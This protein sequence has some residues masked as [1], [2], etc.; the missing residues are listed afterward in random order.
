MMASWEY[1]FIIGETHIAFTYSRYGP[2]W[3]GPYYKESDPAFESARFGSFRGDLSYRFAEGELEALVDSF[4]PA[5]PE[6]LYRF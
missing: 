1:F 6:V 5:D 3:A 2:G 4:E